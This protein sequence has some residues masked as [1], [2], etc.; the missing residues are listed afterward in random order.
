MWAIC[1]LAEQ[2]GQVN[3]SILNTPTESEFDYRV[4]PSGVPGEPDVFSF[5]AVTRAPN[6]VRLSAA[7]HGRPVVN[8]AGPIAQVVPSTFLK[9]GFRTNF[10]RETEQFHV[11]YGSPRNFSFYD[12]L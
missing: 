12:S 4:V 11:N 1:A 7:R 9:A 8:F 5:E 2:L 6:S 3:P 10:G